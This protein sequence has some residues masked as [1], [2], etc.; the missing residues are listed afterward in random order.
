VLHPEADVGWNR[1]YAI[2]SLNSPAARLQNDFVGEHRS[3]TY[4][5]DST[6]PSWL[7]DS[8]VTMAVLTRKDGASS[9]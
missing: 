6:Y 3:G 5:V 4:R 1:V 7:F 8:T 9:P 2:W